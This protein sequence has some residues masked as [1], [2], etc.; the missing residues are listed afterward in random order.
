MRY[1]LCAALFC[2]WL[3]A[4]DNPSLSPLSPQGDAIFYVN[5]IDY[6]FISLMNYTV[7]VAAHSVANG[8]F[9]GVKVRILNN[10]RHS[11]TV[12]PENVR[13]EDA[14]AGRDVAAISGMELAKKMRRPYNWSRYAVNAAAGQAPEA[15]GDSETVDRQQ[16]DLMLAMLM[17]TQMGDAPPVL[18]RRPITEVAAEPDSDI[19]PQATFS[20]EVSHLRMKEASRP[21]V[22]LQLQRQVSPDYVE[23]TS[24]LANTIPPRADVEGVFYYPMGKLARAPAAAKRAAK[25]R[26][27]RVRVPVGE[28]EFQFMLAVE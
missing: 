4:Q 7:V 10:G 23:R 8:K 26:M 3:G 9:L 5:G 12:R 25:S 18:S 15:G 2:S 19:A 1:I 27:V 17:A 11:V 28:V 24:F 22:L 20:D 14:I 21:D 16:R 6:H 13:V